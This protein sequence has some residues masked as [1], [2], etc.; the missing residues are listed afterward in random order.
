MAW[1]EVL[2]ANELIMESEPYIYQTSIPGLLVINRPFF[3]D[4]RGSFHEKYRV[5]DIEA[6][7]RR[8]VI[9]KQSQV[10]AS[11]PGVLRG[12]HVEQQ[13]KLISVLE[14]KVLAV[15]VDTRRDSATFG[16]FLMT[17][18][19]ADSGR[20][21]TI[22]LP[23]GVGNSFYSYEE[24]TNQ[25]LYAYSVTGVYNPTDAGRG[26]YFDDPTLNIPWP[27]MSPT[28]SV[29]DMNGLCSW[30]EFLEKFT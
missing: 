11:S 30:N 27:N 3:H 22:F 21:P 7:L 13:D 28:R 5:P 23:E 15:F 24:H 26:I 9:L 17:S 25:V 2:N 4:S 6:Y 10:S 19:D 1:T 20:T 12:I 29:R 14:G 8:P 18:I 16:K